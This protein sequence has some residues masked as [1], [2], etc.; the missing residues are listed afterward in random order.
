MKKLI[1]ALAATALGLVP[2]TAS[3]TWNMNGWDMPDG[4]GSGLNNVPNDLVNTIV[5]LINWV[6]GFI[7]L[8]A[9]LMLIW[10]GIQYLTAGG[11]QDTVRGAK[12]TIKNALMGLVV[13][14]IA[15]AVV[16][17]IVTI[18]LVA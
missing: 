10:G 16:N 12:E 8:L 9:T 1:S 4:G 3:A 14:G 7:A 5:N 18:V 11:S 15:Y 2:L 17:T 13:A 6:L